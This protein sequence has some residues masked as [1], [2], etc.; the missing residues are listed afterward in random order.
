M[1]F[2]ID[3]KVCTPMGQA[4]LYKVNTTRRDVYTVILENGSTQD[5]HK[6]FLIKIQDPNKLIKE[7]L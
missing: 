6:R 2:E 7:I 4:W 5:F 3:E 1:T